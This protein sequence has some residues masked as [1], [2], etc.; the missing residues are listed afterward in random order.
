MKKVNNQR[1][2]KDFKLDP[3][4]VYNFIGRAVVNATGFI[5][6]TSIFT[7]LFIWGFLQNTI[8]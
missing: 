8:Y 4:K 3:N 2:W 7:T 1:T 5:A 6:I